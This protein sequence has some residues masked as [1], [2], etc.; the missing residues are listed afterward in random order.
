MTRLELTRSLLLTLVVTVGAAPAVDAAESTTDEEMERFLLEAKV[1]DA[2]EIGTGVTRPRK[3]TL[4][5]A[6]KTMYAAFKDVDIYKEGLTRFPGGKSEMNFT[7]KYI[8]EIAAYKLDRRLG[9][10][11]VPVAV[12]RK[13][14]G[15]TGAFVEWIDG[16]IP[17]N[18]RVEQGIEPPD[19]VVMDHQQAVMRLFDAL[20]YN[21]DRNQT[22]ML[23]RKS[24][25]KLF[26]IDHSRSFRRNKKLPER[27]CAEPASLP[28]NLLTQ[29][30]SLDAAELKALLKK[31][32]TG[33]QI[34]TLLQRRD[35]ILEK[36]ADDRKSY[37]DNLVFQ[38]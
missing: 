34:K 5:L 19:P 20:I 37:G 24:D 10:N 6:G 18:D 30:E 33:P 28:R 21:V 17:E 1:V 4:E 22:N 26:L 2:E 35:L 38:D 14:G 31:V 11:M 13:Y 16:A 15:T 12:I 9:M 27:F 36:I 3:L 7:D 25:W 29:L 32:A 23:Y 8:Y